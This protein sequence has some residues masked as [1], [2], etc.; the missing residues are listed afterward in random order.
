MSLN[1]HDGFAGWSL[2]TGGA[3]ETSDPHWASVAFLAQPLAGAGS[4]AADV[5]GKP[6]SYIG[7]AAF[8]AAAAVPGGASI[9]FDGAGD[10]VSTPYNAGFQFD[11]D[12][13]IEILLSINGAG[14]HSV[15]GVGAPGAAPK[16][17]VAVNADQVLTP[18]ANRL[19]FLAFNTSLA[20]VGAS[21]AYSFAPGQT[22]AVAARRTGTAA[23][24]WVDGAQIGSWTMSGVIGP[25]S[26]R[27]LYL[28]QDGEG[29]DG[30][31]GKI[32]AVRITKGVARAIGAPVGL[33]PKS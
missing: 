27:P 25:A 33:W 11:G 17:A 4:Y 6:L 2:G 3:A 22:Y 28:G 15:I 29:Y 9:A 24:L 7:D 5:T 23:S 30:L 32:Y 20:N 14:A 19:S 12:F 21:F 18:T 10:A 8:N 31:A 13:T 1:Y 26:A 16:W